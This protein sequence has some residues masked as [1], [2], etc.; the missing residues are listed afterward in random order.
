VQ[1]F[2]GHWRQFLDSER[3]VVLSLAKSDD[4]V[5]L[6]AYDKKLPIQQYEA[7]YSALQ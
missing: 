7:D 4:G 2:R 1:D 6:S 3:R 5:M